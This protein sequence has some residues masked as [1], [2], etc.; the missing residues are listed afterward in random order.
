MRSRLLLLV[1]LAGL[2]L[3]GACAG[4]L[5]EPI[6]SSGAALRHDDPVVLAL[7]SCEGVDLT[8]DI[9]VLTVDDGTFVATAD[10]ELICHDEEAALVLQ[11]V[12][13]EAIEDAR[14][15]DRA[16]ETDVDGTPLPAATESG[17]KEGTP[18]PAKT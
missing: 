17:S 4:P 12:S 15:A 9:G 3:T 10:G 14:A 1:A 11:G 13:P 6:G 5:D 2:A 7:P 18:L 16:G 8:G